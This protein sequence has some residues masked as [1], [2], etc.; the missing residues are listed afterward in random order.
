MDT[1]EKATITF[2]VPVDAMRAVSPT[3]EAFAC[4]ARLAAAMFWYGR[5]DVSLGFAA[6]LAGMTIRD[7]LYALSRHQQDIF[8]VDMDDLRQV[9]ARG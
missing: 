5:S 9:L 6:Q 2:E 4:E 1:V 8:V 7:F 3:P